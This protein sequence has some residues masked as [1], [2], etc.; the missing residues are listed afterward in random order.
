MKH[1]VLLGDSI[2]DNAGYVDDGDSVIDQL[3]GLIQPNT[4]ATLLAV[5]GDVTVDV[6]KQIGSIP[7][8]ATHAFVSCGGNDA[9]RI[10]NT[11]N[12]EVSSV[13]EA[14]EIFTTIK[15]DFSQRYAAMLAAVSA[16]IENV[17]VCTVHDSV[18]DYASRELTALSMFNEVILR[19][20]FKLGC[21]VIDLRII[22]NDRAD[23]ALISPIEPS[24]F[25][26]AKIA[27]SILT[28][29]DSH[30]FDEPLSVVYV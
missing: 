27:A 8:N 22:C 26:A 9:L 20:A 3:N 21:P 12:Q 4:Q 7:D 15:G 19:E 23:Y 2:F 18:P 14:M 13:G 29:A 16:K 28:V 6:Y 25:G 11:L 17:T 10:A 24:K 30:A 1:L 5:D